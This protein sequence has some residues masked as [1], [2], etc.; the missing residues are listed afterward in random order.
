MNILVGDVKDEVAAADETASS[1][2]PTES[3]ASVLVPALPLSD[4]RTSCI[5]SVAPVTVVELQMKE[6]FST[7]IIVTL[8]ENYMFPNIYLQFCLYNTQKTTRAA[9]KIFQHMTQHNIQ[10]RQSSS[11]Y[12]FNYQASIL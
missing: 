7:T 1:D 2:A 9:K 6:R 8:Y 11:I 4:S 3:P 12:V 5:E 10:I